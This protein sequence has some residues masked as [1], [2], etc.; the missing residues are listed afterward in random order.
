VIKGRLMQYRSGLLTGF[1]TGTRL[2]LTSL[3]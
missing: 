2:D 1:L 3:Q